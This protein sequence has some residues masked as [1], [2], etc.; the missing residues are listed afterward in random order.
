MSLLPA[1]LSL[2]SSSVSAGSS[3]QTA[4]SRPRNVAILVYEG[5]ELLDFTGPGEV[6]AAAHGPRG[7]AFRVYTVAK[8]KEPVTS[9][10]VVEVLPL[11][12]IADCP[13]PDI[14]VVPGG[15]VP[16]EDPEIVRWVQECSKTSELVMSVCNGAMLLGKAGLLDGLEVTTHHGSLQA[17]A[18]LVPSATVHTN[19]RFVD[20]GRVMTSA[21]IS[22]G[23]DG[24]LHVVER[25][26][27]KETAKQVA[28]YMEYDWRPEELAKLHAEPG[29]TLG[30]SPAWRLAA[31]ALEDGH[32]KAL[33]DLR[34]RSDAPD[35]RTLDQAGY[36]L[37]LAKRGPEAV[38]LLRLCAAAYPASANAAD[39]LAEACER[40]G[41]RSA[42]IESSR[43]ALLLVEKDPAFSPDRAALL[44][45][46]AKSRLARLGEGDASALRYS[47]PPCGGGCDEQ[48]YLEPT[49]CPGCG[50]PMKETASSAAEK[51]R[52]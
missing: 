35:E 5:V 26:L 45:N 10:G 25:M 27:G 42:A 23:I 40:T 16:S 6:F 9:L 32:E 21:G 46:N 1:L 41:E 52:D 2:V 17:L 12:S 44:R 28:R 43:K 34:A 13:K 38:A 48:R 50:M 15:N 24:S 18:S 33:A 14:L 3:V 30:D 19:R 11:Y 4:E 39:S 8:E 36:E 47:C 29:K 37:M 51:E 22:A 49:R 7:Q 31:A 20:H